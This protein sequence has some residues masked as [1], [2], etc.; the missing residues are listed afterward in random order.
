MRVHEKAL[1]DYAE[2]FS[3]DVLPEACVADIMRCR[4]VCPDA[5][6]MRML[7]G[8]LSDGFETRLKNSRS[9]WLCAL[10]PIRVKNLSL[11]HI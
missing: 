9:G 4:A 1:D 6:T 8:K 2:R 10:K 11:I 3:D 5:K 7:V